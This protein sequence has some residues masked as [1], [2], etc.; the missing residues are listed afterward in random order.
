RVDS[1][2]EET[3]TLFSRVAESCRELD[4]LLKERAALTSPLL[5]AAWFEKAQPALDNLQR[6]L[7]GI[8]AAQRD[9]E[10]R[11]KTLNTHWEATAGAPA[12]QDAGELPLDEIERL[13]R[14]FGYLNRWEQQ[15]QE[16]FVHCSF[17]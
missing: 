3:M 10:T 14:Q 17:P 7:D 9:L 4:G 16:R 6:L 1:I 8:R 2:P 13:Y 12:H 15:L 5:K 11:L